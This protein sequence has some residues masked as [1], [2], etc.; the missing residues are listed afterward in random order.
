M[1]PDAFENL[2]IG[3][4]VATLALW[5]LVY[6]F[7]V[8][9]K[10]ELPPEI[11]GLFFWLAASVT[12]ASIAVASSKPLMACLVKV[13]DG[14]DIKDFAVVVGVFSVVALFAYRGF[15]GQY[16]DN[17]K[18]D[19]SVSLDSTSNVEER[20]I[21]TLVLEKGDSGSIRLVSIKLGRISDKSIA[22]IET[23]DLDLAIKEFNRTKNGRGLL[24]ERSENA[25]VLSPGDKVT[26]NFYVPKAHANEVIQLA[27]LA[28]KHPLNTF[29][30]YP[31]W[32]ASAAVKTPAV[33]GG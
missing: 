18:I 5:A 30:Y 13:H 19:F 27:I 33:K 14:S 23:P 26:L 22:P 20:G 16:S 8:S 4:L 24:A 7:C 17:L 1:H 31:Q 3:L 29:W 9:D 10:Y 12:A 6:C 25:V 15:A 32:R 11:Q 28:R 2:M 21:G